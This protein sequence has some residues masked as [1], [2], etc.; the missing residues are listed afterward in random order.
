VRERC[1]AE[2]HVVGAERERVRGV[3]GRGA[4]AAV[5]QDRALW[6]AGGAGGEEDHGRVVAVPFDERAWVAVEWERRL[7][8]RDRFGGR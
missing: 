6:A 8:E 3:L 1:R 4:E 5:C 7:D 2:H